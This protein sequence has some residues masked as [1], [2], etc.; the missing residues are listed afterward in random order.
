MKKRI[1]A[2][3]IAAASVL[4]LAGCN[5][6]TKPNDSGA[7]NSGAGNSGSSSAGT[8]STPAPADGEDETLTLVSWSGNTDVQPMIDYFCEKTGT[9]KSK[10]K[11]AT[12]GSKG[13]EARD[14]YATFLDG[15]QDADL[16]FCDAEWAPNFSNSDYTIGLSELGIT[17]DAYKDAYG[18]T[19]TLGTNDAGEF[20]GATWQATPGGFVYRAD[21]AEQY[22]GVKTPDEMQALVSDWT[23]FEETAKKLAEQGVA[24]CATEGGLWQV[25]QCEKKNPWVVDGKL[26]V[27]D[28]AKAFIQM[29]KDYVDKG[30]ITKVKQW[31]ESGAWWA[32][33]STGEALGDF[34]PTWGLTNGDGTIAN[35]FSGGEKGVMGLCEGPAG[36]YWGGTYMMATKKCNSKTLAKQWIEFFTVNADTM[37]GYS[38]K[39]GDFMNNKVVMKTLSEAGLTNDMYK[40]GIHQFNVLYKAADKVNLTATKYDS[41]IKGAFNTAVQNYAI[42]GTTT[43]VDDAVA[44]FTKLVGEKYK[45]LV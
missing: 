41:V 44:E 35:N 13:E 40:D 32:T 12:V 24:I 2:A 22:L 17:K 21:Y 10:I 1:L 27:D 43:S 4:S 3:M 14:N 18:Y 28:D 5:N 7:G 33:V 31:D 6:E 30:Y 16:I 23:K 42:Y 39:T 45:D 11:W 29:A 9:D 20:K 37:Q 36:W 38:E 25:K 34:A 26:K 19:L 8:T 15:D